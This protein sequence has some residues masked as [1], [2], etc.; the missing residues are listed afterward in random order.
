MI[1]C[2]GNSCCG[3][4]R[5]R[6]ISAQMRLCNALSLGNYCYTKSATFVRAMAAFNE[7]KWIIWQSHN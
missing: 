2:A 3:S 1:A 4:S 6:S 7:V 5:V